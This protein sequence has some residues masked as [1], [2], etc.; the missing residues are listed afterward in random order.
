MFSTFTVELTL[1]A[2][3]TPHSA[4]SKSIKSIS[5]VTVHLTAQFLESNNKV[6]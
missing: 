2:T 1:L 6:L 3:P 5:Y 4:N